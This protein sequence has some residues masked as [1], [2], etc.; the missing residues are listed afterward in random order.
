MSLSV[1]IVQQLQ[2]HENETWTISVYYQ[3]HHGYKII[4]IYHVTTPGLSPF[5][6]VSLTDTDWVSNQANEWFWL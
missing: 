6:G 1:F 3:V 2:D 5:H 4:F